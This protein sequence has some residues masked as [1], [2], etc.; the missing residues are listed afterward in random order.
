MSILVWGTPVEWLRISR[1][2]TLWSFGLFTCCFALELSSL[3]HLNWP[4]Q[5]LH[6]IAPVQYFNSAPAQTCLQT[7]N[8]IRQWP[9]QNKSILFHNN[10]LRSQWLSG[11]RNELA[12][13][14]VP[15]TLTLLNIIKQLSLKW[16]VC[17]S[18]ADNSNKTTRRRDFQSDNWSYCMQ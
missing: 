1:A 8:P 15:A 17:S 11:Y 18:C 14:R 10:G 5:C 9:I 7:R 12:W 6:W 13:E 3:T 2:N 4:R 16:Q